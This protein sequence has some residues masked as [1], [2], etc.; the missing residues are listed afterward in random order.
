MPFWFLRFGDFLLSLSRW[1]T[2][3]HKVEFGSVMRVQVIGVVLGVAQTFSGVEVKHE[4][5][6]VTLC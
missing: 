6:N 4:Q 1:R 3:G 5:V 2:R